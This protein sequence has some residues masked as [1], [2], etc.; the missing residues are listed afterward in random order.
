MKL[1]HSMDNFSNTLIDVMA[2]KGL[3]TQ[4]E[5]VALRSLLSVIPRAKTK[6]YTEEDY[7]KLRY[8]IIEK[9]YEEYTCNDVKTLR[10]IA[11][12]LRLE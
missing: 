5:A 12:H 9:P 3:I 11:E 8:L 1:F 4:P 6:Y 7:E 2:I 10:E